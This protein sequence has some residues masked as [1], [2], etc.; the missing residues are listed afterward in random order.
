MDA[1]LSHLG[2]QALNMAMRS[3]IALT[4]TY[5]VSQCSRLL[6][7]VDDKSILDELEGLQ[8]QLNSKIKV[9]SPA[10]D[11]IELKSG[12][13]NAFLESALPLTR[14]LH[15]DINLLGREL[16][17]VASA[18]EDAHQG[19]SRAR[20]TE[21]QRDQLGRIISDIKDLLG[22]IDREIPLLHMA[23]TASGE[24]L[25]SSL[26]PGV[27]PSRL[28]QASAFLFFGDTLY[29]SD[30]E[31]PVQIGP[32]FTLSLYMLFLGHADHQPSSVSQ[33]DADGRFPG[34]G[35]PGSPLRS[36]QNGCSARPYG[37]EEGTRR[38]LWKEVIHKAR[39]RLCRVPYSYVFDGS[40]G[41]RPKLSSDT[42]GRSSVDPAA[43]GPEQ[44]G[45]H[46]EIIEDL[47]DGR[48]HD[49]EDER[50]SPYDD[51]VR[52]GLRESIPVHQISKVFY[53]DTGRI[54]NIGNNAEGEHNPVLL[55]KR[56]V[57]AKPPME[58]RQQMATCEDVFEGEDREP[59]D[60]QREINWQLQQ[61]CL[62]AGVSG[63]TDVPR[64]P[65]ESGSWGLPS[66]LDPEWIALEVFEEDEISE[67]GEDVADGD[68]DF[69]EVLEGIPDRSGAEQE[70]VGGTTEQPPAANDRIS[71]VRVSVD[72]TLT[73][74]IK[75]ISLLQSSPV[76][77]IHKAESHAR[78]SVSHSMEKTHA[79]VAVAR[80]P[81]GAV[82]TSLSLLE[83]LIR[84]TSLQEFQQASHLTIHDHVLNFFLEETSTT[85][86]RGEERWKARKEAKRRVGFDPYADSPTK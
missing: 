78:A 11:L 29:A 77:S 3:G 16:E 75:N 2:Y 50:A 8:R 25:A 71:T 48:V 69:P 26:S 54:L 24:N 51:M 6:R 61:D 20:T 72:T 68:R 10:I 55:L 82:T 39:V 4:S 9:L 22:R 38:P 36:S 46:I 7:K 40:R 64:T 28:M 12:R 19:T 17:E 21:A 32:A 53:A 47:D 63:V 5:A 62:E 43:G 84:L 49:E 66:D 76:N 60:E 27:S 57:D 35:S 70:V 15:R 30:P 80:S 73:Q 18:V 41:Y 81:F 85:G 58:M 33:P 74:R 83:M 44:Y 14:S 13:G 45:Y 52:A 37:V 67:D 56:D 1:L 31:R 65:S 42:P 23:I 59:G 34:T 86:L 79:T